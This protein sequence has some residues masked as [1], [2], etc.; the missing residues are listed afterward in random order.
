MNE[1]ETVYRQIQRELPRGYSVSRCELAQHRL[2]PV[3]THTYTLRDRYNPII[4]STDV[5]EV[6]NALRENRREVLQAMAPEGV[7]VTYVAGGWK[8]S[9]RSRDSGSATR[10][11]HT[12][13]TE[14]GARA[15]LRGMNTLSSA[16]AEK[17]AGNEQD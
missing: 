14:R 16:K 7:E 4:E 15:I 17:R 2:T 3:T 10:E 9:W 12:A 8:I 6:L 13:P 5:V 11:F 1:E